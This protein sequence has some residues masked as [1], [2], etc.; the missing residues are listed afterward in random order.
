MIQK[1][2][3]CKDFETAKSAVTQMDD[4]ISQTKHKSGV[5]TIYEKGFSRNE[6]DS[7]IALIKDL[8][9]PE[10]KVSGIVLTVVAELMPEGTGAL[11]NLI[12]AEESDIEVVRIPC[13]PGGEKEAAAKLRSY[14][15]ADPNARAVELFT[16]NMEL[17]TT[18]FIEESMRGHEGVILFGTSTI[19][20][21]SKKVSV[22]MGEDGLEVSQAGQEM[23]ADE[24]IIGEEVL[25]DGFV[26]TV[27]SGE[28]LKADVEYALGWNPIGRKLPFELG[29]NPLKGETVVN[30]IR[31]NIL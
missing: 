12:L 1:K 9:H 21:F 8:G 31:T 25:P 23:D 18:V 7:L 5:V 2:F 17:K 15:D 6:V 14:L 24:F 19:R 10:I 13:I 22:E 30:D 3:L 16:S 26:A 20:N 28:N 11:F 29:T 27:F 4:I